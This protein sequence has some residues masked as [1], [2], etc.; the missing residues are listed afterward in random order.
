MAGLLRLEFAGALYHI[1]S[2]DDK[3]KVIKRLKIDPLI[4]M[5]LMVI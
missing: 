3:A 5:I 1:A 4:E 2:R